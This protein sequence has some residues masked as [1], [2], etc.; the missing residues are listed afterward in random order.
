MINPVKKGPL[1]NQIEN[2]IAEINSWLHQASYYENK[3][4]DLVKEYNIAKAEMNLIAVNNADFATPIKKLEKLRHGVKF[5]HT[6]ITLLLCLVAF[7]TIYC[8]DP[9]FGSDI[10]LD[11]LKLFGGILAI[12]MASKG[13]IKERITSLNFTKG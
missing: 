10:I 3:F 11:Y 5:S 2:H 7:N 12:V 4:N 13:L 1:L 8:L 6:L 9:I